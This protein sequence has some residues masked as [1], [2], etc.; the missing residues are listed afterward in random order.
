MG[1]VWLKRRLTALSFWELALS[2]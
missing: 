1:N 2:V